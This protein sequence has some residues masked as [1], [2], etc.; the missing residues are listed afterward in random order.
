LVAEVESVQLSAAVKRV[1]DFVRQRYIGESMPI[2]LADLNEL[3]R[4]KFYRVM[5]STSDE[6]A[7]RLLGLNDGLWWDSQ[8]H[9]NYFRYGIAVHE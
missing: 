3:G 5:A 6:D 2:Y 8:S 7:L 9:T 1:Y 4:R